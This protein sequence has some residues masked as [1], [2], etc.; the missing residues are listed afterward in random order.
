[1]RK[2]KNYED[3]TNEEL[4]L[5]KALAGAALGA[6]LAIS[7]PSISQ[8]NLDKVETETTQTTKALK[9]VTVLDSNQVNKIE[10]YQTW[11]L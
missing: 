5:K 4:N 3:F 7:N 1:M 10:N 2:I 9:S 11:P 6:G 8:T